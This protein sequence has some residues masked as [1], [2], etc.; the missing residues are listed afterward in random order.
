MGRRKRMFTNIVDEAEK[1]LA[2]L[3]AIDPELDL[4]ACPPQVEA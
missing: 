1:R 4:G 2:G 3:I